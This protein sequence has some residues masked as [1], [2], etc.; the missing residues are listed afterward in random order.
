MKNK[1]LTPPYWTDIATPPAQYQWL[2]RNIN[3]DVAIIGSGIVGAMCA[4][5]FS[6]A[7]INTVLVGEKPVGYGST[8]FSQGII[9]YQTECG[10]IELAKFTGIDNA[11][12]VFKL[13][14]QSIDT[15]ES[16]C[17]QLDINVDF[18]R[19]NLL[20]YTDNS[21]EADIINQ[22]YLARL[23]NG[24]SVEYITSEKAQS[25]FSFPIQAGIISNGLS[26]TFNPYLLAH[27]L[28]KKA[29]QNKCRVYENTAVAYISGSSGNFRLHTTLGKIIRAKKIIMATGNKQYKT[30]S[31][32]PQKKLILSLVT[33]PLSEF[34]GW[35]ERC[36]ILNS[37]KNKLRLRTT[38]DNRII[39]SGFDYSGPIKK[40]AATLL[41]NKMILE[42]F[43]QLHKKLI[44]MFPGIREIQPKFCFFH[45]Y[46]HVKDN[47]PL[48]GNSNVPGIS[49]ALCPGE[50]GTAFANIAADIL[51]SQYQGSTQSHTNIFSPA[52][53]SEKK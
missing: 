43:G 25:S 19:T 10:L 1:S 3:C 32:K 51:L 9:S 36:V 52:R 48:I 42:R 17:E 53:F 31:C 13:C 37:G 34:L 11:V 12:T 15:L 5:R 35:P 28:V 20:Y 39:I 47:L 26:A 24:F 33:R 44:S 6:Q 23:H 21:T 49:F 4:E 46:V 45:E 16:L 22:E 27:A 18:S 8:A 50:N 41:K 7:G 14:E 2:D 30:L 40:R 29:I 38:P